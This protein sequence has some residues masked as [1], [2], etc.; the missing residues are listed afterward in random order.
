MQQDTCPF[1]RKK[2]FTALLVKKKFIPGITLGQQNQVVSEWWD[3]V[4]RLT[5]HRFHV[6]QVQGGKHLRF[7]SASVWWYLWLDHHQPE[8]ESDITLNYFTTSFTIS[9]LNSVGSS[10]KKKKKKKKKKEVI[11]FLQKFLYRFFLSAFLG[12]IFFITIHIHHPSIML[13]P[14]IPPQP[15][16]LLLQDA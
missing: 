7:P 9:T 2:L 11:S 13:H 10:K 16:S 15:S 14:L 3:Q 1:K 12:E 6:E 4:Q 8:R 5:Q